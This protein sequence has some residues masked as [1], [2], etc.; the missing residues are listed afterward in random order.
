MLLRC[1]R[2]ARAKR[3]WLTTHVSRPCQSY[4]AGQDAR[5]NARAADWQRQRP[6]PVL[7]RRRLAKEC[8]SQGCAGRTRSGRRES[9]MACEQLVSFLGKAAPQMYKQ[10]PAWKAFPSRLSLH[11][12]CSSVHLC[13]VAV[14]Y[15]KNTTTLVLLTALTTHNRSPPPRA[16]GRTLYKRRRCI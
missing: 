5:H 1:E 3:C 2:C 7:L 12:P 9:R 10:A 14:S 8:C 11:A 6:R 4:P 13:V 15:S 16:A